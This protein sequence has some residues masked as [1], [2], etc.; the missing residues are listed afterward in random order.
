MGGG[1]RELV[2]RLRT[3]ER[4]MNLV[5]LAHVRPYGRV[6]LRG[7]PGRTFLVSPGRVAVP[8]PPSVSCSTSLT[9][10]PPPASPS[11]TVRGD[12]HAPIRH[13]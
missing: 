4:G 11:A 10:A 6:Y 12:Y 5:G 1:L 3:R 7:V 13:H 2:G 9:A 8:C